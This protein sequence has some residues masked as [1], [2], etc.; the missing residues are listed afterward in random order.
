MYLQVLQDEI[1]R[2]EKFIS[3]TY[4]NDFNENTVGD[5]ENYVSHPINAYGVIKRTNQG[6]LAKLKLDPNSVSDKIEKIKNLDLIK[7]S[8]DEQDHYSAT[9]SI[10]LIQVKYLV[11]IYTGI[12]CLSLKTITFKMLFFIE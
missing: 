4:P 5:L 3:T 1:N 6:N 9:E 2:V 11:V 12:F 7:F 8:P 10:A